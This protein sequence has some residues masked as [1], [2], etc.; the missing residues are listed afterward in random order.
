MVPESVRRLRLAKRELALLLLI[1]GSSILLQ[2]NALEHHGYVGQDYG[3]HAA[4]VIGTARD[5]SVAF[6]FA[7][8]EQATNPP[9][10]VLFAGLIYRLAGN[11]LEAV[12]L[13]TSVINAVALGCLLVYVRPHISRYMWLGLAV[14][15]AFVPFRVIH[16]TVISHDSLTFPFLLAL[17]WLIA[18]DRDIAQPKARAL[19]L[20][21]ITLTLSLAVFEKYSF[22]ALV[23]VVALILLHNA[24]RRQ[25]LSP[26]FG[27][28]VLFIVLPA[29]ALYAALQLQTRAVGG[30]GANQWRDFNEPPTMTLDDVLLPKLAD[31]RLLNA[32]KYDEGLGPN[33][34]SADMDL[35]VFHRYSYIG[36][37]HLAS[38]TDILNVFQN[39]PRPA[40]PGNRSD[41]SQFRMS[42][43]VKT[44][45]PVTAVV[46][47]GLAFFAAQIVRLYLGKSTERASIEALF[48]CSLATFGFVALGLTLVAAPYLSGYWL[49]RLVMAP[50]VGFFA[51]GFV[52]LDRC[53]PA[54]AV[55]PRVA[56]FGYCIGLAV[57]YCSFLIP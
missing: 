10:Y 11:S 23:S 6:D 43:A 15:L 18:R 33:G 36:L 24:Q 37:L 3:A 19:N 51:L 41:A 2:L 38:F 22:I 12:G 13:A 31:I 30:Y 53:L 25:Q 35:I 4:G 50:L 46:L 56:I 32:P 55:V 17:T 14:V 34:T 45:V 5:W 1:I 47:M 29:L 16:S 26:R 49:P 9:L 52:A 8:G 7:T 54:R 44:S 21:G 39:D 28:V 57:V 48:L 40:I 27:L 20:A 42:I